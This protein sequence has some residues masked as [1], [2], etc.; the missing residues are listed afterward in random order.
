MCM[1]LSMCLIYEYLCIYMHE[2]DYNELVNINLLNDPVV[3]IL[4][5]CRFCEHCIPV[6]FVSAMSDDDVEL[7]K[8]ELNEWCVESWFTAGMVC[9]CIVLFVLLVTQLLSPSVC[10]NVSLKAF[11][12][13][14][15]FPK[16]LVRS[17]SKLEM[18]SNIFQWVTY[19]FSLIQNVRKYFSLLIFHE[20]LVLS[21]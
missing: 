9:S 13:C 2:W 1:K 15:Q 19:D 17:L 12:Y 20:S 16:P 4:R 11:I 14:D 18:F 10:R 3:N 5:V 8:L 21:V 7:F 6:T